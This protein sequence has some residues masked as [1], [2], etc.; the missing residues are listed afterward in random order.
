MDIVHLNVTLVPA[1]TP[2]TVEVGEVGVVTVADPVTILH[3]PVPVT[4]LF[5]AKVNVLVLHNV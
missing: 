2:V 1:A 4:G 3:K 5:P